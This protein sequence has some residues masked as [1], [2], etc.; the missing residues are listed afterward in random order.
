MIIYHKIT[1]LNFHIF[2][3][4]FLSSPFLKYW[5]F[6][7]LLDAA[8]IVGHQGDQETTSMTI[9]NCRLVYITG[10]LILMQVMAVNFN[11]F[12]HPPQTSTA[13][14]PD[15]TNNNTLQETQYFKSTAAVK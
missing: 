14:G 11:A 7:V 9:L 15:I 1:G 10:T 12:D 13:S 8:L 2:Y 4:R 5:I 3:Y 6:H